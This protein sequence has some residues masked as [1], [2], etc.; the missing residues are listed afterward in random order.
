MKPAGLFLI[1]CWITAAAGRADAA[2][3]PGAA[4]REA[5]AQERA[6]LF[7]GL[8]KRRAERI[9]EAYRAPRPPLWSFSA[10]EGSGYESNVNLDGERRGDTFFEESASLVF[11]PTLNPWLAADV[12][13][14]GVDTRFLEF[15]DNDLTTHTAAALLQV[16]PHRTLRLDA[17]GEYAILNFPRGSD[18]SFN[19]SRVKAHLTWAQNGR[20]S[21]KTG[22]TYQFREYD[23]RQAR[24]SAG[25]RVAG[26]VREDQRHTGL[27]ELQ[28][29]FPKTFLRLASEFYRNFSNDQSD[30]FY[31]WDDLKFRGVLTRVLNSRWVAVFSAGQERKNYQRRSVPAIAVSQRDNLTTLSGSL[32]YQWTSRVSLSFSLTYRYQDSND[33]RLDFTDWVNQVSAT[34]SF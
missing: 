5:V 33:P 31:D 21:H 12:S 28:L 15:T 6:D 8:L 2:V 22:W 25:T 27:Y 26:L 7:I 20:V 34:V 4:S 11:H 10:G 24:D 14:T 13:Y 18:S 17:G 23:T 29:R 30:E 9:L 3:E 16:Q 32:I 1:F 19:D